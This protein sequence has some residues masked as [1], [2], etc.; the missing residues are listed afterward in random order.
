MRVDHRG[1]DIVLAAHGEM[2]RR[3]APERKSG[4]RGALR[5]GSVTRGVRSRHV[6]SGA[7][8]SASRTTSR[9]A[10]RAGRVRFNLP[11]KRGRPERVGAVSVSA[12][13]C[14]PDR[15]RGRPRGLPRPSLPGRRYP[16]G[17]ARPWYVDDR[18]AAHSSSSLMSRVSTGGVPASPS[19]A[20]SSGGAPGACP[21]PRKPARARIV[22]GPS[23]R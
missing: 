17:V 11:S 1:Q 13:G 10:L 20:S 7:A 23:L 22:F 9:S 8:P 3:R 16:L 15:P 14:P 5:Q 12:A 21:R 2:V 6:R 18:M 4:R 19:T